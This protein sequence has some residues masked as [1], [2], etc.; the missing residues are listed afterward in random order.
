MSKSSE[1]LNILVNAIG[2]IPKDK[3][4]KV[5]YVKLTWEALTSPEVESIYVP[6]VEIEFFS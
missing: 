6:N 5:K 2:L 3:I 4:N 1:K